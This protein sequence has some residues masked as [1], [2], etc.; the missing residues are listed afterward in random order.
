MAAALITSA[1]ARW[2]E[3][4]IFALA[5]VSFFSLFFI[6]RF[7]QDP[8]YHDFA[9]RRAFMGIPN[10]FDVA[11]NAVYLIAGALGL[12]LCVRRSLSIAWIV[13]FA[14][15]FLVSLGSGYYHWHPTNTTLVWD[16]LPMTVG[17]M[18][19]FTALLC[20]HVGKRSDYLPLPLLILGA[21]S[22][23]YWHFTDDLRFYAWVQAF[24]LLTI[25]VVMALFPAEY[26]HRWMLLAALG[27]YI[28]AKFTEVYDDSILRATGNVFSGH[29][30][31]HLLSG[32][33][34][35]FLYV[36]LRNRRRVAPGSGHR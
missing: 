26:S 7:G 25:P 11:S 15:V 16:R 1:S 29:T 28:S 24:P 18:G 30:I 10:F 13:L 12:W 4:T 3:W 34:S 35:L 27:L 14:G 2:R 17:F 20:E 6:P 31:K 21:A 22:V 23:L 36:M 32:V 5:V 8:A 19:L 9:D 33:G